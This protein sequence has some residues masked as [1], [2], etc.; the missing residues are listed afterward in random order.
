MPCGGG[1]LRP[2]S[3]ILTAPVFE[4]SPFNRFYDS[5]SDPAGDATDDGAG[6]LTSYEFQFLE[7]TGGLDGETYQIVSGWNLWEEG[8]EVEGPYTVNLYTDEGLV[9]HDGVFHQE[10]LDVSFLWRA[11]WAVP[12]DAADAAPVVWLGAYINGDL[13]DDDPADMMLLRVMGPLEDVQAVLEHLVEPGTE[14]E[15]DLPDGSTWIW[16]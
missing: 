8:D 14:G 10:W 11:D 2:C 15:I 5:V 16:P 7:M 1:E 6:G 12:V 3:E 13:D 9:G 4:V